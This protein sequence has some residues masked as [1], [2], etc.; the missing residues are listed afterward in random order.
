LQKSNSVK[1]L[2]IS[3][4]P[5]IKITA[6]L[7][8]CGPKFDT[9]PLERLVE[10]NESYGFVIVD[11]SGC[12]MAKVQG[13]TKTI[14]NKFTVDLPKKHHKG[15]QSSNRFANI[16]AEKR[17]IYTK[18][19]CEEVKKTFITAN[20]PNVDGLVMGGY[21][22]FKTKVY[23]NNVFDGRLKPIVIKV[24]DISY[25]MEQGLNQAIALAQDSILNV[26]LV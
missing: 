24:V 22:D 12:L 26:R 2:K 21:A 17:L 7:Y 18:K 25:G 10:S 14:L 19:V 20:K 13:N 1:K 3:F 6:K 16:R 5:F 4:E 23:E 15:G 11:G 9:T 8:N